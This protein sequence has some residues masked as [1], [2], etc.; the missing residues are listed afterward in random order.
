MLES[1]H[2]GFPLSSKLLGSPDYPLVRTTPP[3]YPLGHRGPQGSPDSHYPMGMEGP[4][5]QDLAIQSDYSSQ[6]GSH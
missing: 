6:G 1:R 3:D 4:R 5:G 2:D